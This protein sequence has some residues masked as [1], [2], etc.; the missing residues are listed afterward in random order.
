MHGALLMCVSSR[1]SLRMLSVVVASW[2]NKVLPTWFIVAISAPTRHA[3]NKANQL[4]YSGSTLRG[5][6]HRKATSHSPSSLNHR[7]NKIT[8]LITTRVH[9]ADKATRP[10]NIKHIEHAHCVD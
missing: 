8:Q 10:N 2:S 5:K 1:V 9:A 3:P 4:M 6:V 7:P